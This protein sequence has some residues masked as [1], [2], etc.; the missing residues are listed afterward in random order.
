MSPRDAMQSPV[1]YFYSVAVFSLLVAAGVLLAV[2]RW[3]LNKGLDEAW[4]SYQGWLLMAPLIALAVFL[5]REAT[6]IFFTAIALL[7]FREFARAT[8]LST[9]GYLTGGVYLGILGSGGVVLVAAHP[10]T[11]GYGLFLVLPVFVIAGIFLVPILRDRT[12]GQVEAL[13]LALLGFLYFGWMYGHIAFLT[14]GQHAYAYLIYLL[15]AVALNDVSAFLFGKLLGR[16]ALRG[17]IS[18]KKTWEGS[19][20]AL[21]VSLALPWPLWFTF[22]HLQ[23]PDLLAIGLIVGVGGQVGD[24]VMSVIK[25][26]LGMKNMS[27]AI[28]GHGGILDRVDSLIYVTP[29]FFHYLRFRQLLHFP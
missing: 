23:P 27:E 9:D 5:G 18:P 12:H 11:A 1:A 28:P 29:L 25:R 2:L 20:G 6:V 13:A 4:R 3:G 14:C 22:P 26:D 7:G 24:L 17:R 19:L 15:V 16:H 21:A 10:L 8:G